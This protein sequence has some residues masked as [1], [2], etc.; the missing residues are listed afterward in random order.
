MLS[1]TSSC[2][3]SP[4]TSLYRAT[5]SARSARE[6]DASNIHVMWLAFCAR[7]CEAHDGSCLIL[8]STSICG[9]PVSMAVVRSAIVASCVSIDAYNVGTPDRTATDRAR[10]DLP[11]PGGPAIIDTSPLRM[12]TW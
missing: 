3:L 8:F 7:I 12:D 1:T 2:M 5:S 10:V 9:S 6:G 11:A 4:F